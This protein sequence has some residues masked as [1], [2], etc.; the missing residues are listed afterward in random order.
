MAMIAVREK[1]PG[2][3]TSL[4]PPGP[5]VVT[6]YKSIPRVRSAWSSPCA[7]SRCRQRSARERCTRTGKHPRDLQ[8]GA[9]GKADIRVPFMSSIFVP[10]RALCTYM[11]PST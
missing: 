2:R 1:E 9:P 7:R 8:L 3:Y 6:H 4:Q 10:A 11:V 5:R